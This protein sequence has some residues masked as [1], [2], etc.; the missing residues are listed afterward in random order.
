MAHFANHNQIRVNLLLANK[1]N[2]PALQKADAFNVPN[3]AFTASQLNDPN[4]VL[5]MLNHAHTDVIIL[6]GFLKLI[7]EHIIQAYPKSILN[8]HPALLPAYGGKGM[9]GMHVHKAVKAAN[10]TKS[11]ISIHLVD[12]AYDRGP[13]VFRAECNLL[14]TD[15]PTDIA[16]KVQQLEH[17]HFAPVIE[18]YINQNILSAE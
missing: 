3:R 10:E 17:K 9:Y 18:N 2:A 11:G 1:P 15:T 8:I 12:E 14:P 4:G 7:P 6:A 5:A 13:V 16:R